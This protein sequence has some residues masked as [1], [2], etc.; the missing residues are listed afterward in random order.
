[1]L[2]L[3]RCAGAGSSPIFPALTELIIDNAS[4]N[5][6]VLEQI[7]VGDILAICVNCP[8]LK[9]LHLK[10]AKINSNWDNTGCRIR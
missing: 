6:Q 8:L 7:D 10:F 4:R 5:G 9:K 1:M 3:P 2:V